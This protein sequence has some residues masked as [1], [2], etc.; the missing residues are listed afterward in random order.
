M[1]TVAIKESED[2]T[3]V[4]DLRKFFGDP[5]NKEQWLSSDQYDIPEV[6]A[7]FKARLSRMSLEEIR[8]MIEQNNQAVTELME[9]IDQ[10]Y[11]YLT[12][13]TESPSEEC[14][15]AN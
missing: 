6:R 8:E 4:G 12:W 14:S 9:K 11:R 7:E 13:M 3:T 2:A 5:L 10:G 15:Y 1:N